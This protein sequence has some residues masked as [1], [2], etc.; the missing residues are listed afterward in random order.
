MP[1]P[2]YQS[3]IRNG[4]LDEQLSQARKQTE[5]IPSGGVAMK[6]GGEAQ[7][8]FP[9]NPRSSLAQAVSLPSVGFGGGSR[10]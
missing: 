8:A 9:F 4:E 1:I 10:R 2:D 7:S 3:L 5:K 6:G